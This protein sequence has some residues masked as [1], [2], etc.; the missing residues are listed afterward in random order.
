MAAFGAYR[1]RHRS[2]ALLTAGLA[3]TYLLGYG[4]LNF[5]HGDWCIGPRYLL[6]LVPFVLLAYPDGAYAYNSDVYDQWNFIAGQGIVSKVS[7]LPE[8]ARP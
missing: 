2:A 5:W 6:P 7:L 1:A 3:V 8:S 4:T